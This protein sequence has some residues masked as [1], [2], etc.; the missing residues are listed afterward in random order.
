M[1]LVPLHDHNYEFQR[2][3]HVDFGL[4]LG[5]LIKIIYFQ[6]HYSIFD[7]SGIGFHAFF[8]I[9]FVWVYINPK[10]MIV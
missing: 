1:G 5:P 7:Y 4:F 6:F 2:S 3:K 8:F 10:I 9:F